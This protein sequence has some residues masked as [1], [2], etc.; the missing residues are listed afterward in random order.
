MSKLNYIVDYPL[1]TDRNFKALKDLGLAYIQRYAGTQWTNLNESD[2]GITILEQVC[3]ALTELGY[4]NDFPVEDIL[5]RPNGKLMLENQFFT[6]EEILTT[7][8]VTPNDY[9]KYLIDGIEHVTNAVIIPVADTPYKLNSYQVYLQFNESVS[10]NH[11]TVNERC[12][13]AFYYLNKSRNIGELFLKPQVLKPKAYTISGYI[14]LNSSKGLS[15]I[16]KNIQNHIRQAIF[17]DVTTEGYTQLDAKG[18]AINDIFN[19][20]LLKTGWIPTSA[21]GSKTN[22][23]TTIAISTIITE[24]IS[25]SSAFITSFDDKDGVRSQASSTS[26]E[27]LNINLTESLNSGNLKLYY[28]GKE[29]SLLTPESQDY[30]LPIP[31]KNILPGAGQQVQT[32]VPKGRYRDI[33]TY[34]SIQNTFPEIY[35]VGENAVH[36]NTPQAQIAQSRQ[37]KG[38]LT[39]FDQVLANQFSQLANVGN[40]FSFKNTITGI[41]SQREEYYA[42]QDAF[43][44][45]HP[46]YP[47]PYLS[48]SAT[49][50]YQTLYDVPNIR[51]L[52]KDNGVFNFGIEPERPKEKEESSWQAYKHDPYNAYSWGLMQLMEDEEDNLVRRNS[53]LDHL[54]ARHGESPEIITTIID[55]TVYSGNYLKDQVIFKS[56][57]LQN[58]DLLSYNRQKGYNYQ[59]ADKILLEIPNEVP[60]NFEYLILGGYVNDFIFNSEKI[61][62]SEKLTYQDFIN[63]SGIE[64][65]ISL[66]FGL[67]IL[68]KNFIAS[69][70]HTIANNVFSRI[71][72]WMITQRCGFIFIELPLLIKS[73]YDNDITNESEN[74]LNSKFN[75]NSVLLLF[76]D[77]IPEFTTNDFNNRLTLFLQN[78]ISLHVGYEYLT[79]SSDL[80]EKIIPLFSYW[81]NSLRYSQKPIIEAHE[82]AKSL[83]KLV[84]ELKSDSYE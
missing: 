8:P 70:I 84:N 54:L 83:L 75:P 52:L 5:T 26:S 23:L 37:L 30:K 31:D 51:A 4:C 46:E 14:N 10:G 72:F 67:K 56:L 12:T 76:P 74:I 65:K 3:Y 50:F 29:L 41:P 64:L 27:I 21:L 28:K 82:T 58:L 44:K 15:T 77:F 32:T 2:P 36:Y 38:Y 35:A 22:V 47:V 57:Y 19:G 61:D 43:Q 11:T 42:V 79:V 25:V 40:L 71:A 18:I 69:S 9:I 6:P 53:I 20:P 24:C 33:N 59:E 17:P 60:K 34:Y 48:F 68:Y 63:Y 49:Y 62:A 13:E 66:L 16:V 55:S 39:L 73:L 1:P 45:M 81:H 7:A 78:S 80:L